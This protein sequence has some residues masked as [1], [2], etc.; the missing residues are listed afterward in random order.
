[1]LRNRRYWTSAYQ[2]RDTAYLRATLYLLLART[3]QTFLTR[4]KACSCILSTS[5]HTTLQARLKK[6]TL[7]QNVP[8]QRLPQLLPQV[9]RRHVERQ[10]DLLFLR[11]L[12]PRLRLWGQFELLI[13]GMS[14]VPC[15]SEARWAGLALRRWR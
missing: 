10:Q 2:S 7:L 6:Q 1:D 12:L 8:R 4:G 11:C 15:T 14:G 13:Q 3:H 5:Y 9:Q